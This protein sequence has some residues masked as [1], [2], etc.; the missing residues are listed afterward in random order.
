MSVLHGDPCSSVID[1][2]KR[3]G[4]LGLGLAE[5]QTEDERKL[6][7]RSVWNAGVLLAEYMSGMEGEKRECK[8]GC[9]V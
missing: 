9:E 3:D 5:A 8:R 4:D 6:F 7:G 1:K 2:S